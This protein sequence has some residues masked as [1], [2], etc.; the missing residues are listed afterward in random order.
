[1]RTFNELTDA[2]KAQA[3]LQAAEELLGSIIEGAVRFND[4]LNGDN[5]QEAIDGALAKAEEMQTPWFAGAYVREAVYSW[6]PGDGESMEETVWDAI[7]GM[8][9]SPVEDALYPNKDEV[10]IRLKAA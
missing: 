9:R 10:I 8:A 3:E 1:M 2:E 5:L 6:D 4:E 7:C